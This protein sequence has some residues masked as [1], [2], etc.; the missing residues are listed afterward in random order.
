M[1]A[2]YSGAGEVMQWQECVAE[3]VFSRQCVERDCAVWAREEDEHAQV[4]SCLCVFSDAG[5]AFLAGERWE[6]LLGDGVTECMHC[7]C[8]CSPPG[9]PKSGDT[10]FERCPLDGGEG[11]RARRELSG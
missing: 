10:F 1:S 5:T 3:V 6:C 8:R 11:M 7:L 2:L 9:W 4:S